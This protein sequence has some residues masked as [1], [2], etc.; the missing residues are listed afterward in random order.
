MTTTPIS[1]TYTPI[2]VKIGLIIND[3]GVIWGSFFVHILKIISLSAYTA[4]RLI[5]NHKNNKL[6]NHKFSIIA[7]LQYTLSYHWG[8]SL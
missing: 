7:L 8:A 5:Q 2:G 4:L 1:I 3:I 6:F